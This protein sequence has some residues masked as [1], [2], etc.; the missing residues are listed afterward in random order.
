MIIKF[1][2]NNLM[3]LFLLAFAYNYLLKHFKDKLGH[4]LLMGM[5]LSVAVLVAMENGYNVKPGVYFDCR[6]VV[7]VVIGM[8]SGPAVV[9]IPTGVAV[10]YRFWLG[11]VAAVPGSIAIICSSLTGIGYYWWRNKKKQGPDKLYHFYITG[12][13]AHIFLII[14]IFMIPAELI[15][16]VFNAVAGPIIILYPIG[17]VLFSTFMV[18][19]EKNVKNE[20][21]LTRINHELAASEEELTA[22]NQQL[23]AMNQQLRANE[24]KLQWLAKFPAENP[25]PVLRVRPDGYIEYSNEVSDLVLKEFEVLNS[26]ISNSYWLEEL[27]QVYQEGKLAKLELKSNGTVLSL[28]V[29]PIAGCSYMN[30]YSMDVTDRVQARKELAASEEKYR[31]LVENVNNIIIRWT[32]E[33]KV[34]FINQYGLNLL[35]YTEEELLGNYLIGTIVPETETS[36]RE[37]TELI[38]NIVAEPEKYEAYENENKCKDG[39]RR[40]IRWTNKAITDENGKVVEIFAAGTDCTDKKKVEDIICNFNKTMTEEVAKR[41]TEL[42]EKNQQLTQEIEN[43]KQAEENLKSTQEQMLESEKM[44]VIGKLASGIAHELNTPMGAIGSTNTTL[45]DGF[46]KHIN[47]CDC[48]FNEFKPF[49]KEVTEIVNQMFESEYRLLSSRERR[50]IKNEISEKLEGS[51]ITNCDELVRFLIDSGIYTDYERYLEMFKSDKSQKI[52]GYL[53]E[54]SNIIQ[55]MQII[56]SAVQQASRITFALRE[57][58]RENPDSQPTATDIQHTIETA[59]ILHHNKIK[60]GIELNLNFEEVPQTASSPNEMVQVWSN[61][62]NNACQ[63]MNG[64]GTMT[65]ELD[66]EESDIVVRITDTGCGIAQEHLGKIFD[67]L[68]TTKPVGEGT[69]L[70]L[71]I[72]KRIVNRHGGDITVSSKVNVGTTFTVRLPIVEVS[73]DVDRE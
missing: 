58:A 22:A 12:V 41:T 51:D 45:L 36:G 6:S 18:R 46:R 32:P 2:A 64:V 73:S 56:S 24:E 43:R 23:R 21:E 7:L 35:G 62:I 25:S 8:F 3:V 33:G 39:S 40:W 61:L 19:Q 13:I 47:K 63:A 31:E 20:S 27:Y 10:G 68:F 11:G 38:E 66:K 69:G 17:T 28:A 59:L 49:D 50:T 44:A 34:N 67:P 26:R 57:Y 54:I 65:I 16:E 53:L 37:L 48:M 60:H 14:T 70:G 72:I 30:I 1:L 15:A 4:K 9:A 42:Y 55:G 71:D 52:S 5:I 29:V